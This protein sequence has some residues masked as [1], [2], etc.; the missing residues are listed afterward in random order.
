VKLHHAILGGAL[1][2]A[3]ATAPATA[4]DV[5]GAGATFPFPGLFEV[6]RG[7]QG[8]LHRP[9]LPVERV[10]REVIEFGPTSRIFVTPREKRT[11]NHVIGSFG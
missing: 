9:E 6:G 8:D 10:G 11:V 2:V 1:A 4:A 7:L 3:A 5:K